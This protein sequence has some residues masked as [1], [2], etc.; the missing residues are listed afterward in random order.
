MSHGFE[1]KPAKGPQLPD[2]ATVGMLARMLNWLNQMIVR[3]SM[4]AMLLTAMILTYSVVTRYLFKIPT[5]WQDEAS[6]FMLIGVTFFS[7]AYVQSYRGHIGI[8]VLSS[9]LPKAINRLRL[10]MVDVISAAFCSF[11]SWK[12]W[13]LFHEAWVDGQTTSS[14]F[15]PPLWIPYAMMAAGM[16][17]LSLQIVTQVLA[18][19]TA[20]RGAA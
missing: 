5:D 2:N 1:L 17:L 19:V 8:E 3:I 6:V 7:A 9:I 14:T 13:T 18:S 10:L 4:V 12:S 15:A 20:K 11:F 16:T